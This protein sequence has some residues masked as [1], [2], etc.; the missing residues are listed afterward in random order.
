MPQLLKA[1]N[2]DVACYG[3]HD[4]D[5]GES[6]LNELSALSGIEWTLTNTTRKPTFGH[7]ENCLLAEAHEYVI[8]TV[9]GYRIGFFGLAGT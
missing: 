8:K 6:R 4:F 9:A 7:H 1:L 3:N 5:F 2:I